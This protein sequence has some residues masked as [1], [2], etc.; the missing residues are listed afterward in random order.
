MLLSANKPC[1]AC[2]QYGFTQFGL[3]G[4]ALAEVAEESSPVCLKLCDK[5]SLCLAAAR[6]F[7]AILRK[8][9]Q[10]VEGLLPGRD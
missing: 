1:S 8:P 3:L 5:M 2:L 10:G 9:M 4:R 7:L 6:S